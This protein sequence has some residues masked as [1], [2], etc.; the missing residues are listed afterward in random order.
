[1]HVGTATL[2]IK[3]KDGTIRDEVLHNVCYHPSFANSHLLSVHRLGI[4]NGFDVTFSKSGGHLVCNKTRRQYPFTF[5]KSYGL[6]HARSA[7]I[8][9]F[10]HLHARFGHTTSRRLKKLSTRCDG[11]PQHTLSSY[12]SL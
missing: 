8:E 2:R 6:V 12:S 7:T 4:D 3:D 11:F 10:D 5:N 1:M 9:T